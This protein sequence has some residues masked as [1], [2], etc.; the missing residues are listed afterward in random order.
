METENRER[1]KQHGASW[2]GEVSWWSERA[3][4]VG[5]ASGAADGLPAVIERGAFD[6]AG[7]ATARVEASGNADGDSC[8]SVPGA[9]GGMTT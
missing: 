3:R 8:R 1:A 9:D 4:S 2:M 7:R 6:T 5:R